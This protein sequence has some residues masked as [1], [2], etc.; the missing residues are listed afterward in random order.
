MNQKYNKKGL[1]EGGCYS[2]FT[3]RSS[4]LNQGQN[5]NMTMT[6]NRRT[7]KN[8]LIYGINLYSCSEEWE[9][10]WTGQSVNISTPTEENKK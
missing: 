9:E 5:I 3:P 4:E 7:K 10:V 6:K 1:G 8:V 2:V